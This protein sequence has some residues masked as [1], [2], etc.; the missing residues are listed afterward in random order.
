MILSTSLHTKAIDSFAE[1]ELGIPVVTLMH[2]AG[3]AVAKAVRERVAEGSKVVILA[4]KGNNGGDGYAAA[5]ELMD[6]Y[7]VSVYDIFCAGQKT[8]EGNHFLSLYK[9]KGGKVINFDEFCPLEGMANAACIVD[10]I[11]GTGFKGEISPRLCEL[12]RFISTIVGIHKIA[13][14]VP[15]GVNADDGSI[16]LDA[17]CAMTATVAL[18]YIKPGLVSYPGRGYVGN[19]I[20]DDLGLPLDIISEKFNFT[21]Y[22]IDESLAKSLIPK[23][24]DNSN[25]GSFGKLL[26]IVGSEKYK[27]AAHLALEAAL[28]GGVGMVSF[29]GE[30]KLISSLMPKFPEVIY[31]E[32]SP[33]CN[34]TDNEI[35]KARELSA[36]STATL[37]GCGSGHEA[38]LLR[39]TKSFL[40]TEGS[41]L[42]IDADALNALA[43]EREESKKLLKKSKRKIVLTP[44]PLEFSRLVGLS[45]SEVQLNRISVAERF[46]K[47]TGT[48]LVLKGASTIVTD[49]EMTYVNSTG[50]SALA[51][52]GSG[53]VL[54]GLI[55]SLIA[56]GSD[57]LSAAVLS[58]Y[59]HGIAADSLAMEFS[60]MGVLVSELPAEISRQIA[61]SVRE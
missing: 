6:Q 26:A 23:R 19:L 53:D 27:G 35:R 33:I 14:D 12:S 49:G 1:K 59:Y 58:V 28:R 55:A 24:E 50:S 60:A 54:A 43:D 9:E 4:G 38:G 22:Y 16:N 13:I 61:K 41:A 39:L 37:I 3:L 7:S 47:E 34:I 5:V 32:S 57:P 25:K 10:A 20:F 31:N 30:N 45:T 15:I 18:S 17:V 56:A 52:A 8:D 44:H 40:R 46:A 36:K 29:F 51:K 11:F 48:V 2:R 21:H 42:V